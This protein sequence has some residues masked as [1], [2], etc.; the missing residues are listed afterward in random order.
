VTLDE[1]NSA[2]HAEAARALERCC[3][4]ARW[5]AA[6]VARRPFPSADGV[7]RAAEE[8]WWSLEG[9]DWLEAFAHHPRIGERATGWAGGEQA[10]VADA[11][12]ATMQV[13]ARRNREY[14]RKFTHVFLVCATGRSAAEMLAD[15]EKRIAN[16]PAD[17][18][19]IAAGEQAKITRLRLEKLLS[20]DP[21]RSA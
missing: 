4:S 13:L 21:T 11:S 6:M 16:P 1:L 18:L 9:A 3:G 20:S 17:E 19:R 12:A 5:V 15:L 8:V 14:E 2:P 7:Y 10:G